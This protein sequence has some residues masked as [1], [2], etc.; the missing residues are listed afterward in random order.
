M[1]S[2][3][4]QDAIRKASFLIPFLL[5]FSASFFPLS[6]GFSKLQRTKAPSLLAR[7]RRCWTV[8]KKRER[9]PRLKVASLEYLISSFFFSIQFLR[10]KSVPETFQQVLPL[11]ILK[12]APFPPSHFF[13][14][15]AAPLLSLVSLFLLFPSL[16]FNSYLHYFCASVFLA[17]VPRW[18][19]RTRNGAISWAYYV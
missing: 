4:R 13:L 12:L 10:C 19:S 11:P 18:L 16:F 15:L 1:K 6:V 5:L 14:F 17:F 2:N 9:E 3:L 7:G 8:W